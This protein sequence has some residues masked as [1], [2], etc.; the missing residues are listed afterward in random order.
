MPHTY[1]NGLCALPFNFILMHLVIFIIAIRIS[2]KIYSVVRIS[3][4]SYIYN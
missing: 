1:I 4:S 2:P 3:N